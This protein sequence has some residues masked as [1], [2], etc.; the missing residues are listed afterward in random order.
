MEAECACRRFCSASRLRFLRWK[1]MRMHRFEVWAPLPGKVAVQVNRALYPMQGPDE[2]GWWRVDVAEASSGVDYGFLLDDDPKPYPDPRS[3][4]Q[5]NG[6]HAMSRIFDQDLFRWS[7]ASFQAVPLENA[8]IYELHIGTFTP[9]GTLDAAIGKLDHLIA[10]GVTHVELMPVAA[11]AGDHGWGYDG[12]ALFAV[13]E[14]YGGP[15][16]LK[17]FVDAAHDRG[18][19]VLLDVVYN[20]FGPVGNYLGKFGPYLVDSHRTPWGDAVNLEEGWA[21]QVR[22]Y[23]C[24][25]ALMWLREFHIDGLRFDAVHAFLDRSAIHF[26]EQLSAEVDALSLISG[27]RHTLIAE[28]D[29]NDPRVVNPRGVGGFGMNAQWSDDFHHALFAALSREPLQ[30]YYED[31]GKL[32][33]LAKALEHTF[34]YDGIYSKY[35]NRIQGRPVGNAPQ[36][37]FLG[38]IQN[39]DQIGNRALGD[40]VHKAV[41]VDRARIAAAFVLL[42]P[43][44]PM[45]FQGEEWA[46]SSPFQYFANHGDPALARLIAE[47]RR[48]EFTGFGWDPA[49]I[50]DPAA[51]ETFDGS[52]LNWEELQQEEH[53]EMLA[54]Y[55][56]L[57]RLRRSA[58][59]A[60]DGEP[61][62]VRVRYD[63]LEQWLSMEHGP[64]TVTCN[65]SGVERHVSMSGEFSMVLGSSPSVRVEDGAAILPSD[66]VIVLTNA[67]TTQLQID[68]A[69]APF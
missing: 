31:F 12:V 28:S 4:W 19:A 17:R 23:L 1:G 16:A 18:L 64:L 27:R 22:R 20:H 5:P 56:S 6:V 24:D 29:L 66:S 55:R 50:P 43:F 47:G 68:L 8:L 59:S 48:R 9:H 7:D 69:S 63:E 61:A 26:I 52:V 33:H 2:Q 49:L 57:I 35:R 53:A 11:F 38:Y 44:V 30:G 51:M 21:H 32:A 41:G 54:W 39:H 65:L 10:L 34:V 15:A 42:G 25:N 14:P 58:Y 62:S 37:Q 3:S 60:M 46:A 13:H 36:H 67:K 45:L 40:R